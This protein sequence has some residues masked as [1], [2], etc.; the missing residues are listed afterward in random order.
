VVSIV[1]LVDL[2]WVQAS[3]DGSFPEGA[4]VRWSVA[5]GAITV[6][7]LGLLIIAAAQILDH[8]S[9]QDSEPT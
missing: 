1:G 8:I 6:I 2:I 4:A 5:T 7:A 3:L 9:R